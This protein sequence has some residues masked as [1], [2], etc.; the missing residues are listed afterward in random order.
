MEVTALEISHASSA[1]E[2][3]QWVQQGG[4]EAQKLS[5]PK[6]RDS[7]AIRRALQ[8]DSSQALKPCSNPETL[9]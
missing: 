9:K 2:S 5:N 8:Q 3:W 4:R 6:A 7:K 1:F